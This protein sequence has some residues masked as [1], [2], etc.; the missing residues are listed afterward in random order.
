MNALL[1][2]FV[3]VVTGLVLALP[4]GSC[5]LVPYHREDSV[6][7]KESSCSHK[8]A[9]KPPCDSGNSPAT[10]SVKCCCAQDTALPEKPV[11]P[12]DTPDLAYAIVADHVSLNDGSLLGSDAAFPPVRSGPRLQILLC[13]WRC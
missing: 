10:P 8:T 4:P 6:P 12:N 13:V 9:P 3:A 11:Q 2:Q 7:V 5:V 1:H